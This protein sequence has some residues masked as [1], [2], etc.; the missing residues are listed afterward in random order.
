MSRTIDGLL[1]H[2]NNL[3]NEF[4]SSKVSFHGDPL[5]EDIAV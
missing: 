5:L 3:L 1:L 2:D 4:D